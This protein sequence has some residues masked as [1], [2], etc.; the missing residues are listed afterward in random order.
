MLT[1]ELYE[2]LIGLKWEE[3]I[4]DIYTLTF[5]AMESEPNIQ[6]DIDTLPEKKSWFQVLKDAELNCAYSKPINQE[7]R[8]VHILNTGVRNLNFLLRSAHLELHAGLT[9]FNS[10]S[11]GLVSFRGSSGSGKSTALLFVMLLELATGHG[12]LVGS[13]DL[14]WMDQNANVFSFREGRG[15]RERIDRK[16]KYIEIEE[17]KEIVFQKAKQTCVFARDATFES[18]WDFLYSSVGTAVRVILG[19]AYTTSLSPRLQSGTQCL[20]TSVPDVAAS[21]RWIWRHCESWEWSVIQRMCD[22]GVQLKNGSELNSSTVKEID[23]GYTDLF[24]FNYSVD[25]PYLDLVNIS[26]NSGE[27]NLRCARLANLTQNTKWIETGVSHSLGNLSVNQLA[28]LLDGDSAGFWDKRRVA[29]LTV[30]DFKPQQYKLGRFHVCQKRR[31]A[32]KIIREM[33][34]SQL[35]RSSYKLILKQIA[36]KSEHS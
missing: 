28:S 34:M 23:T 36:D 25:E 7:I 33:A 2:V 1:G 5:N 8:V 18:A 14:Y 26:E 30:F 29:T 22:Q 17:D 32:S 19:E 21:S 10:L 11:P 16:W 3:L 4:F 35:F 13:K 27:G 15:I 24:E 31:P 12:V 20:C 9:D 6:I